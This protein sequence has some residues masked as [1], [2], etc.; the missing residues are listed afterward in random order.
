MTN[1][2]VTLL[3]KFTE[4]I[5]LA[6]LF[7]FD[8]SLNFNKIIMNIYFDGLGYRNPVTEHQQI[9]WFLEQTCNGKSKSIATRFW[10]DMKERYTKQLVKV[11]AFE[12]LSFIQSKSTAQQEIRRAISRI[13]TKE[14]NKKEMEEMASW[15]E[16]YKLK[17]Y[18]IDQ[19]RLN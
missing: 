2:L 7:V 19:I 11:E 3:D 15:A 1:L 18:F 16:Q 12:L 9:I 10:L 8:I 13:K 6:I 5:F 4:K 14:K 17:R